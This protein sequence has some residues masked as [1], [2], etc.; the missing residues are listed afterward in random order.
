[1]LGGKASKCSGCGS[2]RVSGLLVV[3]DRIFLLGMFRRRSYVGPGIKHSRHVCMFQT[4]V[5]FE[6][7]DN[8]K[9][10]SKRLGNP[11]NTQSYILSCFECFDFK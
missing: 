1:M 6:E 10:W 9:Q 5:C 11:S 4:S 2:R 7:A 8:G 3:S